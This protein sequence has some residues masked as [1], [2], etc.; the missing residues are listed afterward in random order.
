MPLDKTESSHKAEV[1]TAIS[2]FRNTWHVSEN[3]KKN[4]IIVC[5]KTTIML[6]YPN[7]VQYHLLFQY[8][9]V[10]IFRAIAVS[11]AFYGAKTHPNKKHFYT[12]RC[13]FHP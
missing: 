4:M 11:N 1:P 10:F 8:S 5:A 9:S 3:V 2:L 13:L 7:G 6:I 12:M